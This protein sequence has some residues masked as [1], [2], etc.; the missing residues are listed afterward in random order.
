MKLKILLLS[1]ITIFTTNN[2]FAQIT[3]DNATTFEI[4]GSDYDFIST[5]NKTIFLHDNDGGIVDTLQQGVVFSLHSNVGGGG[6]TG[7]VYSIFEGGISRMKY[8]ID[9]SVILE[10]ANGIWEGVANKGDTSLYCNGSGSFL[11]IATA[12]PVELS[13]PTGTIKGY[14][15]MNGHIIV[16]SYVSADSETRIYDFDVDDLDNPVITT[17]IGCVTEFITFLDN[18]QMKQKIGEG[19]GYF[20]DDGNGWQEI[21]ASIFGGIWYNKYSLS[22][23]GDNNDICLT[24]LETYNGDI[25][26]IYTAGLPST[27]NDI[28]TFSFAE[29]TGVAV[30]NSA[31]HTVNIEVANG[32]N[33]TNLV[34]TFTLSDMATAFVGT[35]EQTSGTTENDFSSPVIY[36]I[37]AENEDAQDWTITVA[38][39]VEIIEISENNISIFPNPTSGIINI[40]TQNQI[41]KITI[42]DISGKIIYVKSLHAMSQQIEIDLSKQQTGTYFWKN[43]KFNNA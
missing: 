35:T 6:G 30:I 37:E 33:L 14:V 28:V 27:E 8:Y 15:I 1:I 2:I 9:N 5:Q 19:A 23:Y 38:E 26:Q 34:A 16:Y 22:Y 18:Y 11:K 42:L 43:S 17:E 31:N 7:G 13:G 41:E 25:I 24:G 10:D 3:W 12:A 4:L 36:T 39:A 40:A 29:Q 32:T 21:D 20:F